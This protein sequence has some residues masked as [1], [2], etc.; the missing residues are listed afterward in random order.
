M[1]MNRWRNRLGVFY[2]RPLSLLPLNRWYDG[3]ALFEIGVHQYSDQMRVRICWAAA[4]WPQ[5]NILICIAHNLFFIEKMT[6]EWKSSKN[7]VTKQRKMMTLY[8]RCIML[9]SVFFTLH[10]LRW[11]GGSQLLYIS[12][13]FI[14]LC[15]A[16]HDSISMHAKWYDRIVWQ[17]VGAATTLLRIRCGISHTRQLALEYADE[18]VHRGKEK[19]K[20]IPSVPLSIS[21]FDDRWLLCRWCA[22]LV[23]SETRQNRNAGDA[24]CAESEFVLTR[25]PIQYIKCSA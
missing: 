7:A 4:K 22:A 14:L 25:I 24:V 3:G 16:L 9:Y 13:F 1:T 15:F 18:W 10:L 8:L 2:T 20:K 5:Q 6:C 17:G 19:A 23:A 11:F 12:V 21:L